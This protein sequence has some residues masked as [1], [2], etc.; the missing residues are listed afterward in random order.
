M[1]AISI[2]F[3]LLHHRN[4]N[5]IIWRPNLCMTIFMYP[6]K[7]QHMICAF[8]PIVEIFFLQNTEQTKWLFGNRNSFHY[9]RKFNTKFAELKM[10]ATFVFQFETQ[11]NLKKD[12]IKKSRRNL[13]LSLP[14]DNN[15]LEIKKLMF[16]CFVFS[17]FTY[18]FFSSTSSNESGCFAS[19]STQGR[20][21]SF[22]NVMSNHIACYSGDYHHMK[23]KQI[24]KQT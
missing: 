1:I 20:R 15:V 8:P 14:L 9:R 22:F 13:L 12:K 6:L 10:H 3:P 2:Y 21:L 23:S 5:Q 24:S 17:L 16:V 11:I 19:Q 7:L 4:G 18:L